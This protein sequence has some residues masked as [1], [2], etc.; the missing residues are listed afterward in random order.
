MNPLKENQYIKPVIFAIMQIF[1]IGLVLCRVHY[2][3]SF[4]H[5]E[6][7]IGLLGFLAVFLFFIEVGQKIG[8]GRFFLR[9]IA[10]VVT[11]GIL[12]FLIFVFLVYR[13]SDHGDIGALLF[14][15][16]IF[17]PHLSLWSTGWVT[18]L[19]LGAFKI[20]SVSC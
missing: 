9:V 20:R 19:K 15:S 14:F 3:L 13:L 16:A 8:V 18:L 12:W 6:N 17:V 2:P 7:V 1:A 4:P 5:L 11:F 10:S